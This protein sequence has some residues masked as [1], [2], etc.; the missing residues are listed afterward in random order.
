MGVS[1]IENA[2]QAARA[3]MN[4][5]AIQSPAEMRKR[6]ERYKEVASQHGGLKPSIKMGMNAFVVVGETDAEAQKIADRAYRVWH[7]SFHYLYHLHGRSPVHG[8]R[9]DNFPDVERRQLGVAGSP[10]TVIDVLSSRIAEAGNN[11]LLCQLAFGDMTLA[12]ALHSIELF[13]RRVMP[14]LQGGTA[15]SAVA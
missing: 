1:S 10:Q 12:E 3:N 9:A 8:E 13:A 5:V 2:E 11:Y 4:F 15:T 14:A 6:V 7:R